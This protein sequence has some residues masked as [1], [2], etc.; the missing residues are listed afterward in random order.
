MIPLVERFWSKVDKSGDCWLW[1]ASRDKSGYG[2]IG[3]DG[4]VKK[5]HRVVWELTFGPIP[6]GMDVLHRCDNPSCV[7][8]SHLF[9]GTQ[10]VN[11][12]DRDNKNRQAMGEHHGRHKL[13]LN[14]VREIIQSPIGSRRL[15]RI[16]SVGRTTIINIRHG[17]TWKG[18]LNVS[19]S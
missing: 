19:D 7:N 18:A 12:H 11:I 2:C 3:S 16:F 14:Q 17:T 1:K 4:K 10:D 15:A 13:T 6:E 8:P 9:L 5:A